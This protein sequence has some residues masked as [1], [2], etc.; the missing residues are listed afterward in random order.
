MEN[1]AS[2]VVDFTWTPGLS[3]GS[4]G[5]W[6]HLLVRRRISHLHFKSTSAKDNICGLKNLNVATVE[7]NW[8]LKPEPFPLGINWGETPGSPDHISPHS[9]PTFRLSRAD[10]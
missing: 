6:W 10:I 4:R 9:P 8:G 5:I 1:E 3:E 7:P 2:V